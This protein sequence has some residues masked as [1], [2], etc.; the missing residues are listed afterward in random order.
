MRRIIS[1]VIL[2]SM[3]L[4]CASRLGILSSFYQQ[5]HIIAH[6]IG[7]IREIPIALC[8]SDY[9][10]NK[11][12]SIQDNDHSETLPAKISH[13]QEITLFAPNSRFDGTERLHYYLAGTINQPPYLATIFQSPHG[14]IFQPPK[15]S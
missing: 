8:S 15:V 11:G 3:M 10:F 9:D 2:S 12:L 1:L 6:A 7:I 5:R 13:A 4:H 14:K